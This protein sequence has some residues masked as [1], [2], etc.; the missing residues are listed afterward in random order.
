MLI[1]VRSRRQLVQEQK[2]H[3]AGMSELGIISGS[4]SAASGRDI[5]I[6]MGEKMEVERHLRLKSV[7]YMNY[8]VHGIGLI[9]LTQN[10]QALQKSWGT[11][12]STVSYVVSAIGVGRLIAYYVFGMLSDKFGRKALVLSGMASYAI[13]FAGVALTHDFRVAY[14]LSILAGVGNSALDSGTYPTFLELKG[15]RG[16]ANLLIK[17][18][19]SAGEFL[20]PLAVAYNEGSGG[21]YG[22]TFL[23][24]AALLV[25]NLLVVV[26][27]KFPEYSTVPSSRHTQSAGCGHRSLAHLGMFGILSVYGYTSMALMLIFTQWMTLYAADVLHMNNWSAHLLLSLYSAGSIGG[28]ILFFLLLHRPVNEMRLVCLSNGASFVLFAVITLFHRPLTAIACSLLLGITA[29]GGVMQIGLNIFC[30]LFPESKGRITGTFFTFG[31]V[32]SFTVP[33]VTGRLSQLGLEAVMMSGTVLAFVSFLLCLGGVVV[34]ELFIREQHY[35]RERQMIDWMD[36]RI[37]RLLTRRMQLVHL[38]GAKKSALKTDS[39]D[40]KRECEMLARIDQ[41]VSDAAIAASCRKVYQTILS[42]SK[43]HSRP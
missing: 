29:A 2:W 9:I 3:A 32:A 43:R 39:F 18:A 25:I 4:C 12:L 37:V 41:S 40:D 28:V 13:F 23:A 6:N 21:W 16:A 35:K 1:R 36:R 5:H 10:M 19:M 15:E 38:I 34:M 30:R 11:P 24:A 22:V 27:T 17:A 42:E 8:V 7:L 14:L 20:L 33:I 31:S 26:G